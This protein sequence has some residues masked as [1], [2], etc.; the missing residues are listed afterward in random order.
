MKPRVFVTRQ[1]PEE[2]LRIIREYYE[3][4][5]WDR[6]TPPPREVLLEKARDVDALVTLLTDR[7]DR[8]LL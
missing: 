2:G 8:E 5:V 4:E 7:I 6:Y 1:I 3:V